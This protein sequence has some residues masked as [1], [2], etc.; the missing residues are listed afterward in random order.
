MKRT[1]YLLILLPLLM[2]SC[3]KVLDVEPT[4]SVSVAEAI[5][6]KA[7]VER[8]I[9]G[10]YTALQYA[11]LYGRNRVIVGDLAADNLTWTGTTF[12][13]LQIENNLINADNAI[14][15]GAWSSAYDGLNRVNNMLNAMQGIDELTSADRNKFEGEALFLRAFFHYN[16]LTYYGAIPLKTTPT[17][18]ITNIDQ[19]RNPLDQVYDQIITDL[20]SAETKLPAVMPSGR[21]NAS[22]A[23]ALLARVYLTRFH[24]TGNA[25]DATLAVEKATQLIGQT[26]YA[27]SSDYVNLY[28]GTTSEVIFEIVFDAQNKNRLAEYFFTRKL[29]GRYEIAPSANLI[30]SYEPG[31][32]RLAASIDTD[33]EGK[34]YCIKYEQLSAGSDA[35]IVLRLAEQYLIK[36]EALAYTNGD[37]QTIQDNIDAIRTRAGLGQTNASTYDALKLAIENE[38]RLEFAFEGHRWFD[39]VRTKRAAGLL[40]IDEKYTLFP[41]PLSEMQTN[42]LMI[43]NDGY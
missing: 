34:V 18:D 38:R 11:G 20:I 10:S 35:V 36:A 14:L 40:G 42:K 32:Q 5:K 13:Y 21:A 33:S 24:A 2:I 39:L 1:L 19:A 12:E 30:Q 29:A 7:G 37:I 4:A 9:I 23:S 26:S 43:Q 31:D 25:S 3:A 41:I 22:A 17:L 8:A 27:L 15:E 16:L 28:T 6:D